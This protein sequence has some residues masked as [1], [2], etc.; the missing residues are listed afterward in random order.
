VTAR[1]VPEWIGAS[2]DTA[3]PPRVKVRIFDRQSGKCANCV[4]KMGVAGEAI[5]YD[6]V[7][8]LVNGGEN[9]EANLQALCGICHSAKTRR[10]VAEKSKVNRT[11]QKHLG[12]RKTAHPIPGGKHSKWKRTVDGRTIL[13]NE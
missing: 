9:R 5:E 12:I 10:D 6:H 4:R 11:R 13:R 8:A 3:M 1:K 2:T 7:I